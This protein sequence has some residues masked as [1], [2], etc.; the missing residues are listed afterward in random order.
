MRAFAQPAEPSKEQLQLARS[1]FYD[2]LELIDKSEWAEAAD[3]L[4]R[5]L[6]IR[7][8]AVVSYHL[9]NAL[10]HLNKFVD[11]RLLLQRVLNDANASPDIRAAAVELLPAA[12][13]DMGRLTVRL[14]GSV[15]GVEILIDGRTTPPAAL[16]VPVPVD[17]HEVSVIAMRDGQQVASTTARVG[18]DAGLQR[19]VVL[20]IPAR[21]DTAAP[22]IAPAAEPAPAAVLAPSLAL[23]PVPEPRHA[24]ALALQPA[25]SRRDDGGSAVLTKWWFW[26]AV[27]AATAGIVI[28]TVALTSGT[29]AADLSR[30][31][32]DFTPRLLEGTVQ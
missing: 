7:G 18:G 27:A 1:L 25:E 12:E 3:R 26:T 9:A 28:T 2:G 16:D 19:E 13:R 14:I 30:V 29:R 32:G 10:Y 21:L 4:Q 23:V 17:P 31:R 20:E 24:S 8:S 11:A 15:D 5:V 22:A 6:E